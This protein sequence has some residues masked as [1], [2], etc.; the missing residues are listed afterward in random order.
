[1][2]IP[3]WRENSI[4]AGTAALISTK[5]CSI[6]CVQS[7]LSTINCLV[8]FAGRSPREPVKGDRG[9]PGGPGL[10]GLPGLEGSP[11][12]D[13]GPGIIQKLFASASQVITHFHLL[14]YIG[15]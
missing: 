12:P 8:W 4:T 7:L 15:K 2:C 1:M 6:N 3:K 13:G 9:E 5:L 10:P 11:G 14:F